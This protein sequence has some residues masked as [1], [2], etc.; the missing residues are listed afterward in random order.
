M[1]VGLAVPFAVAAQALI[2]LLY[3]AMSPI[4]HKFDVYAKSRYKGIE[5]MSSFYQSFY[6]FVIFVVFLCIFF[7]ADKASS[8]ISI[9]PE[10]SIHGLSV[11][12]GM[13]PAVGFAMLLKRC[14]KHPTCRSLFLGLLWLPI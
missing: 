6:S 8:F 7:G 13:M 4:M 11:A 9:L 3:T 10:W 12:G 2:T 5:R 1:T 14:G